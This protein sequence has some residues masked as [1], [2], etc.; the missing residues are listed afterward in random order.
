MTLPPPAELSDEIRPQDDLWGFVN[1]RWLG[2]D[3]IPDDRA[4]WGLSDQVRARVAEE[5]REVIAAAGPERSPGGRRL[6]GLYHAVLDTDA[7][8][9]AGFE[10]VA[11]ELA[12]IDAVT[13]VG[14]LLHV[15][16]ERQREGVTGVLDVHAVPDGQDPTRWSLHLFQ[17]GLT[18]PV[19]GLY[20]R[21]GADL[22]TCCRMLCAEA[23]RPEIADGALQLERALA[24]VSWPR[25]NGDDDKALTN[26]MT[27][28]QLTDLMG[29]DPQPL[30]RGLGVDPDPLPLNVCQPSYCEGLGRL[31]RDQPLSRWRDYLAWRVIEARATALTAEAARLHDDLMVRALTGQ[32]QPAP[33]WRRAVEVVQAAL[34]MT[35]GREYVKGYL[36]PRTKELAREL[37]ESLRAQL[38]S[39]LSHCPWLGADSRAAAVAKLDAVVVNVGWPDAWP[40]WDAPEPTGGAVARLRAAAAYETDR[41]LSVVT[42]PVD[43]SLWGPPPFVFNAFYQPF[44]NQLL[45]TGPALAPVEAHA[46]LA[47]VLGRWGSIMGHELGH[48]FDSRGAQRDPL[49]RVREWWTGKERAAFEAKAARVAAQVDGYRPRGVDDAGV[50]GV[51]VGF[52]CVAELIGMQLAW[53]TWC[54]Q[55]SPG[56]RARAVDGLTGDQRFWVAKAYGRRAADRSATARQRLAADVHPPFEVFANLARNVDGF[57][58]AFA[59]VPGDGMWLPPEDRVRFF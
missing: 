16:G 27:W 29:L 53:D 54:A 23:G 58:A 57:H 9:A 40:A 34:P 13:G 18:L 22:A 51:L 33:P 5:L 2:T 59:T 24:Q 30:L 6:A 4:R 48:A 43:R 55:A 14:E 50:D 35:L 42:G 37:A 44:L 46:D 28:P 41:A 31:L 52:E 3:P 47:V 39:S 1:A 32:Q 56:E 45:V 11:D 26:P 36:Q 21:L 38:R 8:E 25:P 15:L 12:V 49:G 20:D 10:P 7:R 17:R 19:P